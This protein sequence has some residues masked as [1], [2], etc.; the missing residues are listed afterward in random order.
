[1]ESPQSQAQAPA[2][3]YENAFLVDSEESSPENVEETFS[4]P[5]PP[6]QRFDTFEKLKQFIRKWSL[7]HRYDLV[8]DSSRKDASG[9]GQDERVDERL[10]GKNGKGFNW[11]NFV[12]EIDEP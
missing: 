7:E 3:E 9:L 2:T 10:Y 4:M 12:R 5:P 8:C 11:R 6:E 1:M